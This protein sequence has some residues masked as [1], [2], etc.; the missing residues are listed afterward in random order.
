[1]HI[2][3]YIE[4]QYREVLLFENIEYLDLYKTFDNEKLRIIFSTLHSELLNNFKLMNER[5]PT[6]S[7]GAHFWAD[8]SRALSKAIDIL[9][10]LLR[11]LNGSDL[12]FEVDSYYSE[13]IEKCKLF[14]KVS[15]GS[16]IPP[17]M[18]K[19]TLYYTIPIFVTSTNTRVKNPINSR[20]YKLK[21]IG[22]G[23]YA[24][25]YMYHETYAI[26]R[27]LYFV[28]TGKTNLENIDERYK[29]FVS[30]G[31][32]TSKDERYKNCEEILIAFRTIK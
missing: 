23:S 30:S 1:M 27:L 20:N 14:L 19:I 22:E 6:N 18:E 11:A 10:G 9:D 21:K 16:T 12:S 5:L 2:T 17:N 15:G 31:L 7:S 29:A 3:N 13:T 4:S 8:P 32:S 24:N 25:V 26:T 28:L